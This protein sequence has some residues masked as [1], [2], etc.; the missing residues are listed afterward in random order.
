MMMTM[1][2]ADAH[3]YIYAHINAYA[4]ARIDKDEKS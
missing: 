3:T 2:N 4:R 1:I